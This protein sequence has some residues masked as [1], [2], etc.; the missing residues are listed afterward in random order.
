MVIW[1]SDT[2]KDPAIRALRFPQFWFWLMPAIFQLFILKGTLRPHQYWER[3][4]IPFVAIAA[5]QGILILVNIIRKISIRLVL[6][7]AVVVM[8][9]CIWFCAYG[10]KYYYS[11]RWQQPEKL[12]MF[13]ELCELIPTDAA[14]LSFD[15]FIIDQFL[16]VK[17]PSYRPEVA[18]Y[19]DRGIVPAQ[20]YEDIIKKAATGKYEFYLLPV[21]FK[22][23]K[24]HQLISVHIKDGKRYLYGLASPLQKKFPVHKVYQGKPGKRTDNGK[25]LEAAMPT[26]IIFKLK[27]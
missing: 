20:Q 3:P 24:T 26:Y 19:L 12:E 2:K 17:E 25:F 1:T 11:V 5:A 10:T 4:L 15:P 14:L 27:K 7:A 21:H 6:S 23:P 9:V 13:E 16:G 8:V 22:D 18:W